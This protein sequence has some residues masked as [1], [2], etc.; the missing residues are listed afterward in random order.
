MRRILVVEDDASNRLGIEL[1][2]RHGGFEVLSA[3]DGPA[4][5]RL[6]LSSGCDLVVLDLRLPG[7]HGLDLMTEARKE[8]PD[9][10]FLILSAAGTEPDKVR[11]LRSGADDYMVKPFGALELIARVEAILRR[12]AGP[13]EDLLVIGKAR[14]DL[15]AREAWV[16]DERLHLTPREY[17]LL[18]VLTRSPRRVLTRRAI[19]D[20]VWGRHYEGTERTVDNFV[21]SLR[22]KLEYDPRHPVY[23]VTVRG[24]G[25][26]YEP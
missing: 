8:R 19:L 3:S 13:K 1:A 20:S 6:A 7:M 10:A 24:K 12:L 14:I 11:G 9:L 25:Y 22:K 17:D 2:L 4:G 18:E 15:R 21:T 16:G 5:L 23:L 26:K